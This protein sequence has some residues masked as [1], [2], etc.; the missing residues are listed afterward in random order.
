[1]IDCIVFLTLYAH[2]PLYVYFSGALKNIHK[3]GDERKV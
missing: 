1:M 2:H 3:E